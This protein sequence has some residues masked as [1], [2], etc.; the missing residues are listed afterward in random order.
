MRSKELDRFGEASGRLLGHR[1]AHDEIEFV[2][3]RQLSP[4]FAEEEAGG[5][6]LE[7]ESMVSPAQE[8]ER[9]I[10]QRAPPGQI[11][12]AEVVG[13]AVM[14]ESGEGLRCPLDGFDGVGAEL[15]PLLGDAL[16]AAERPVGQPRQDLDEGALGDALRCRGRWLPLLPL[17]LRSYGGEQRCG[18]GLVA[19]ADRRQVVLVLLLSRAAML[20]SPWRHHDPPRLVDR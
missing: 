9:S 3:F 14:E 7:L 17:L 1:I 20:A 11:A 8:R 2:V 6:L 13:Q 19:A 16:E 4:A 12:E 18:M 10:D 15:A 5:A